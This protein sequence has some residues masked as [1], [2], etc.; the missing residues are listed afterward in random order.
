MILLCFWMEWT[1]VNTEKII[2]MYVLFIKKPDISRP[3]TENKQNI[4]AIRFVLSFSV[5]KSSEMLKI[6]RKAMY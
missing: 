5:D 1:L 2:H 4:L 6:L 3:Q